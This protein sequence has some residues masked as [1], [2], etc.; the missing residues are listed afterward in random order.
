MRSLF[1]FGGSHVTVRSGPAV[2]S[3]SIRR[4]AALRVPTNAQAA[5]NLLTHCAREMAHLATL[6]PDLHA[7]FGD[8]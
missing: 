5:A 4:L 1:W 6:L 7:T 8:E 3:R 2:L